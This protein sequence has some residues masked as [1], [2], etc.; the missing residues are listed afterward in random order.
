MQSVQMGR[1]KGD[2]LKR[3][4]ICKYGKIGSNKNS[5]PDQA[6]SVKVLCPAKDSV[7]TVYC[8]QK[9]CNR[10]NE[11]LRCHQE[12]KWKILLYFKVP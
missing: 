6:T 10:E 8:R 1:D 7:D 4:L 12:G 2:C 9:Q 3:L 11:I 5:V